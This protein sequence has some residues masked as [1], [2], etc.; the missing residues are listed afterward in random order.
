M[1]VVKFNVCLAT[2]P[3][4]CSFQSDS[5]T[6]V[7]EMHPT[8]MARVDNRTYDVKSGLEVQT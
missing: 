5:G 7:H 4:S 6:C 3:L 2:R 8:R 1:A